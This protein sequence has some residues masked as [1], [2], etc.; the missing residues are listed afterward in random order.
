M[1]KLL[2]IF[3]FIFCVANSF[4]FSQDSLNVPKSNLEIFSGLISGNLENIQDKLT[5]LGNDKIYYLKFDESNP[6]T[7]FY[8]QELK[9][10]LYNF[11][12]V[13]SQDIKSDYIIFI[14]KI[15]CSVKYSKNSNSFF[16][17]RSYERKLS[18]LNLYKISKVL[19]DSLIYSGTC[20]KEYSD[21]MNIEFTEQVEKSNFDF[22]KGD[23]PEQSF[24][25]KVFAPAV[26]VTASLITIVLFYS[27]RSK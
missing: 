7:D 8:S 25:H 12:I 18:V 21:I 4:A 17:N 5:V 3:L 13:T 11:K 10:K 24:L 27:I 22:T 26:L 9:K 1:K 16:A 2:F 20:R 15:N 19:N 23:K 14:E 6:E